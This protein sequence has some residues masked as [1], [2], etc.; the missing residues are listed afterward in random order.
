MKKTAFLIYYLSAAILISCTKNTTN[1]HEWV[2]LG[3]PSGTKWATCNV[4]ASTPESYGDYFAWGEIEKK[5]IYNINTYKYG[6]SYNQLTKYCTDTLY[7]LDGFADNQTILKLTDDAAHAAWGGNW[8]M[9]TAAEW[10]ELYQY[11]EWIWITLNGINGYK[12]KSKI[13]GNSIFLLATGFYFNGSLYGAGN[14]ANYWSSSI[15]TEYPFGAACI[16]F[17]ADSVII[18]ESWY[19][20]WGY[21]VRPVCE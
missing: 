5:D 21:S 10:K 15:D 1:G 9:P 6:F 16:G 19:R 18:G 14:C 4:G 3:L 17:E 13:N 2:D 8:R 20:F 7:G 11:C 12:V